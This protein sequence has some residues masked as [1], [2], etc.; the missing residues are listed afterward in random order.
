[1]DV[2]VLH[3]TRYTLRLRLCVRACVACV[4]RIVYVVLVL[5]AQEVSGY[6]D[7]AHR[8]KVHPTRPPATRKSTSGS[9]CAFVA[10][11]RS[12]YYGGASVHI[13]CTLLMLMYAQRWASLKPCSMQR[14]FNVQ[15][16]SMP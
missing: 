5:H 3:A 9:M 15:C 7:Y 6:I 2:S 1:M 14:A 8:L 12:A 10:L 13:G 16:K 11:P 4:R